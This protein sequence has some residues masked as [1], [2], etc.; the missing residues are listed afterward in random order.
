MVGY[1]LLLSYFLGVV[2]GTD[3]AFAVQSMRRVLE[4]PLR[5]TWPLLRLLV[6]L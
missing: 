2:F 3:D 1:V 6:H 4:I 5:R